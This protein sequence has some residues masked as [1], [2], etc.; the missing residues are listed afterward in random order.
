M[1]IHAGNNR[2]IRT[3]DIIGIFDMDT[4][5]M[6]QSTRDYLRNAERDGRMI[7]IKEDIPKSFIVTK[8]QSGDEHVYVSQISTGALLG[9]LNSEI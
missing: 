6:T 5:T 4:A 3:R 7:N 8:N 9:R 1:Y 2:I